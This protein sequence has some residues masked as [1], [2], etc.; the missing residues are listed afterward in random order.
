MSEREKETSFFRNIILFEETDEGRTLEKRIAEVER[1]QG[2][3]RKAAGLMIL[4]LL[5]S[6]A[7]LVYGTGMLVDFPYGAHGLVTNIASVLGLAALISLAGLTM[8]LMV[9]R[10]KLNR[11]LETC[12]GLVTK[13]LASQMGKSHNDSQA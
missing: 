11:L 4:F 6:G 7:G 10:R 8:L 3:V 2:C 1:D 12:R 5:L 9:Y 13:R